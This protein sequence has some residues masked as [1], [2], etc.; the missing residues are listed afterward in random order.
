MVGRF[1]TINMLF[2][3]HLLHLF[4][5]SFDMFITSCLGARAWDMAVNRTVINR[6]VEPVT[7]KTTDGWGLGSG[8]GVAGRL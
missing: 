8:V 4:T 3:T 7:V 1:S 2:Q 5:H 6:A